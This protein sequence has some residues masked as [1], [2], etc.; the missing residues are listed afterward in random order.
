MLR[1]RYLYGGST[2]T[3]SNRQGLVYNGN[4]VLPTQSG[5]GGRTSFFPA[6]VMNQPIR[7]TSNFLSLK[8][9]NTTTDKLTVPV[10]DPSG[11]YQLTTGN[12]L[13]AGVTLTGLTN[14]YQYMLTRLARFDIQFTHL[15]LEIEKGSVTQFSSPLQLMSYRLDYGLPIPVATVHPTVHRHS[16]QQVST[17]IDYFEFP[18]TFDQSTTL[19]TDIEAETCL[20]FNFKIMGE[21]NRTY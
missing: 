16:M 21:W 14:N 4:D 9:E 7:D 17:I 5:I 20:I 2:P 18:Y 11:G 3:S 1:R 19:V 6:N 10:L 15:Q 12:A 13:P 8:V